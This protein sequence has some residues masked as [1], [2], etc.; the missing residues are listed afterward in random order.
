MLLMQTLILGNRD[1][2]EEMSNSSSVVL[3]TALKL[4]DKYDLYGQVAYPKH[5]KQLDVPDIYRLAAKTKLLLVAPRSTPRSRMSL[6][7]QKWY[8]SVAFGRCRIN[9]GSSVK[10]Q[11]GVLKESELYFG[12]KWQ[13]K[14]ADHVDPSA[15]FVNP[16]G[17]G[18]AANVVSDDKLNLSR[19]LWNK[20]G[21]TSG[22]TWTL[23]NA[24]EQGDGGN[25]ASSDPV[26]LGAGDL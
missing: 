6:G 20:Y 15:A 22:V 2:I 4:I 21:H 9:E 18:G 23:P 3:T 1:D 8:L 5:H 11:A 7:L 16:L 17:Y 24:L 26:L 14:G 13:M 25:V 19:V 12:T 10:S